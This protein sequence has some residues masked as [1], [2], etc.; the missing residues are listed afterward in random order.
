VRA[1]LKAIE[2]S[3]AESLRKAG[4]DLDWPGAQDMVTMLQ[5][6]LPSFLGS[7]VDKFAQW[8]QYCMYGD[9]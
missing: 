6:H 8:V 9:L 2:D 3:W 5:A 7:Y 4:M 1:L